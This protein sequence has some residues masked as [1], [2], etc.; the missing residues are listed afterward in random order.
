[1]YHS[2]DVVKRK[3]VFLLNIKALIMPPNSSIV[4]FELPQGLQTAFES[5]IMPSIGYGR[6]SAMSEAVEE[7]TADER[8]DVLDPFSNPEAFKSLWTKAGV[9]AAKDAQEENARLGIDSPGTVDGRSAVRTPSGEIKFVDD[10][11]L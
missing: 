8:A 2:V 4:K 7:L 1:L 3:F 10:C 5:I 6:S 9:C 11:K